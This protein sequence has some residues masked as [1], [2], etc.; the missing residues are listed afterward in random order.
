MARD[1][2]FM[3]KFWETLKIRLKWN[4]HLSTYVKNVLFVHQ[5]IVATP[6]RPLLSD[7]PSPARADYNSSYNTHH[8]YQEL[9]PDHYH[10]QQNM[11]QVQPI[12]RP[13]VLGSSTSSSSGYGTSSRY[14]NV[15][16]VSRGPFVSYPV[17]DVQVVYNRP[18]DW[19]GIQHQ[20]PKLKRPTNLPIDGSMTNKSSPLI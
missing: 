2:F 4:R 19:A 14:D 9:I 3:L 13:L 5:E 18:Q 20:Q 15:R 17:E 10:Y 12:H 11:Q 16:G 8:I 7:F 6:E 1:A